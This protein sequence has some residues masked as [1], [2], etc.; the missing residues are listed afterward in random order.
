MKKIALVLLI[1]FLSFGCE[2][3]KKEST[4]ENE[5]NQPE[6]IQSNAKTTE[7]LW[8]QEIVLD[9]DAKWNANKETTEGIEK[10]I[11]LVEKDKSQ[12]VEDYKKLAS[13][14]NEQK[15]YIVKECTMKGASHDNLHVFL[16]P[17][18]TKIKEL[19][20]TNSA[21]DGA[22]KKVA[23]LEHLEEYHNYFK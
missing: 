1:T 5:V 20:N 14:L 19:E 4:K 22:A 6:K 12:S 15:K 7:N 8:L 10:M 2:K 11:L 21:E 13:K 9:G 3:S 18:I 16:L 23:I 17:L